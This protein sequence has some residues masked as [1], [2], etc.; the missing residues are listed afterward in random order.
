MSKLGFIDNIFLINNEL[1]R[2]P[3][4][5][6]FETLKRFHPARLAMGVTE[7]SN[8]Y[9][10]STKMSTGTDGIVVLKEK[11]VLVRRETT[12]NIVYTPI[13]IFASRTNCEIED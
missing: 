5:D 2:Q 13:H 10:E 9:R 3:S 12:S 6:T 8:C 11:I 1:T 7:P 4:S